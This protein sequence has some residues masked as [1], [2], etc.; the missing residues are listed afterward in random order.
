[1]SPFRLESAKG[2]KQLPLI[3]PI[4][5]LSRCG[6]KTQK[7]SSD[8]LISP[9]HRGTKDEKCGSAEQLTDGKDVKE[10]DKSR[11]KPSQQT[12]ANGNTPARLL[13]LQ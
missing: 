2:T 3:A 7:N 6:T 5:G 1:M 9:P 8:E 11:G 13:F 10:N 12:V 4:Q